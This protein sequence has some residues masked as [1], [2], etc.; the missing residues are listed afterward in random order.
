[1]GT[2]EAS[3]FDA[4]SLYTFHRKVFGDEFPK[5]TVCETGKFHNDQQLGEADF[6][7]DLNLDQMIATV[8]AGRDAYNLKPF[9]YFPLNSTDEIEYRHEVMQ[10]LESPTLFEQGKIVHAKNVHNA[11]TSYP[12]SRSLSQILG[13]SLVFGRSGRFIAMR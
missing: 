10:D 9:F 5:H 11:R 6:F 8:T 4:L 12:G 2:G 3:F 1:M 7:T 13:R